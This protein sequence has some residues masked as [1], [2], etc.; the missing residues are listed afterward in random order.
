MRM[1]VLSRW[2]EFWF[3]PS[4]AIGLATCRV[5]FFGAFLLYFLR[6]DFT[7]LGSVPPHSWRA[8]WPFA[9]LGLTLPSASTLNVLQWLWRASLLAAC[10]GAAWRFAS[11]TAF[12]LGLYL[13]GLPENVARINHSDAIVVFGL[14]IMALSRAADALSVD[15]L[16]GRTGENV[17]GV[18]GEYTWPIRAMWVVMVTIYFAAGVTKLATSGL[19]WIT[20]DN[21]SNL[22]MLG[23]VTGSP[24]TSLGQ[25]IGRYRVLSSGL[26]ALALTIELSMPLVLVSRLARRILVPCLFI[27]QVC[28]RALMGPGFTEFFICGL[29]WVPWEFFAKRSIRGRWEPTSAGPGPTEVGRH[30]GTF[31]R[32]FTSGSRHLE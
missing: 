12:V 31:E 28:I 17:S 29:F 16:R 18:S 20:T 14:A 32:D 7:E 21:L 22:L 5:L 27:M 19:A 9:P 30:S 3:E 2:D 4:A 1:S 8:V 13:I 11:V 23:A 6:I 26:A 10:L 24:L 15:A 25:A